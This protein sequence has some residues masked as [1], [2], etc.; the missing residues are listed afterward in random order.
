MEI[1]PSCFNE[2]DELEA[3][4]VCSP[5]PLD[6]PDQQTAEDVQW[7]KP[8]DYQK[9]E[10]QHR[11]MIEAM[12]E[13]GALVIDYSTEISTQDQPFHSQLIN[14]L[15]TRD[16]AGVC[17]KTVI[18][19]EA[20]TSMRQPEYILSHKLFERWFPR[21][22]FQIIK[23]EKWKALE[24]GDVYVLN[25]DAV[26]INVGMRSSMES[27]EAVQHTLFE[28]GFNEVAAIDLPRRADT[29]HL[30]MN[31]N[32]VG[33]SHFL[34]KAYMRY[35]PVRVLTR[36]GGQYF[37]L[38]DFLQ[39]HG[40]EPVWTDSVKSTLPDLNFLNLNPET[41]LVS[42]KMNKKILKHHEVLKKHKL[43]EVEIDEL[44]KGGGG[45]RCMTLPLIR[46]SN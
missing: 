9:A 32:M 3:V 13:S 16:L 15:F 34:A 7:A 4:L 38:G 46:S 20:A 17:G 25:Q 8:F 21:D 18:P 35:F 41:L 27:V 39:R 26:L 36:T 44:E 11:N 30:D 2:H 37:M 40:I 19:G 33:A 31:A 10:H 24:F 22:C 14:R 5:A 45:I 42:S 23:N 29:M 6:V 43:I 28:A 1:R 12:K